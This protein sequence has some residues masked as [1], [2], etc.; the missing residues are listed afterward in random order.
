MSARQVRAADGGAYFFLSYAHPRRGRNN[1]PPDRPVRKFYRDLSAAVARQAKLPHGARVGFADWEIPVGHPWQRELGQALATCGVFIALYT[2]D[3]FERPICGQ[4]WAAFQRREQA[5]FAHTKQQTSAIMP[6]MWT[7]TPAENMPPTAQRI[8]YHFN[9]AGELYRRRGMRELVVRDNRD[10]IREA[11][12]IAVEAFAARI[13]DRVHSNPLLPMAGGLLE[14]DPD[15]DAF[16][17]EWDRGDRRPLRF[18][19]VAPVRGRLPPGANPEMYGRSPD[20]WRPYWPADDTPIARTA[21]ELSASCGFHPIVEFLASCPDLRDGADPSA[22][23]ILIVDPWSP[24]IAEFDRQLRA[25][26]EVSGDKP[27][28]RLMIPW[29]RDVGDGDLVDELEKGLQRTLDRLRSHCR[30]KNPEAVAGLST[31]AAFGA[32]LQGVIAAAERGYFNSTEAFP[33]PGPSQG[34]P[35]L[36]GSGPAGWPRRDGGREED[37]GE[38]G[39]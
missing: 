28:V 3:Y 2:P 21:E 34:L 24:Q 23:T 11:Y 6:V 29:D 4:E 22:P 17:G 27:W 36:S 18:V 13:V 26:D 25:F 32:R 20:Q 14:L 5:H 38:A 12:E 31:V 39:R 9:E 15:E 19:V 1:D 16:T 30:M 35:R 7:R 37:S 8:H 10:E 33:P